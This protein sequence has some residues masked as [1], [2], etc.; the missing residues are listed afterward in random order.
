[1][2]SISRKAVLKNMARGAVLAGIVGYGVVLVSRE[3]KVECSS[4]CG[5]CA[6][7][8]DGKC[9]LGLK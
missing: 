7:L 4:R 5:A 8:Q 3:K 1:M 6:K 9:A 2:K